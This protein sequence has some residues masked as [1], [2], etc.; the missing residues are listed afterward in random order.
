MVMENIRIFISPDI[1]LDIH[2]NIIQISGKRG[3]ISLTHNDVIRLYI[4]IQMF[5]GKYLSEWE[6]LVVKSENQIYK[7]ILSNFF[8]NMDPIIHFPHN[9]TIS[10]IHDEMEMILMKGN[11]HITFHRNEINRLKQELRHLHN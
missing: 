2:D 5:I 11:N 4:S 1:D 3:K 6:N 7:K 9:L 10:F 8:H